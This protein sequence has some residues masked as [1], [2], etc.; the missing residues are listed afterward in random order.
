MTIDIQDLRQKVLGDGRLISFPKKAEHLL[1]FLGNTR[2]E[3]INNLRSRIVS[4]EDERIR[5]I[6][7]KRSRI[8]EYI[9]DFW[10]DSLLDIPYMAYSYRGMNLAKRPFLSPTAPQENSLYGFYE[11]YRWDTFFQNHGIMLAGGFDVAINQLLNLADVFTEYK[12]IPN[13]LASAFLSHAHPPMEAVGFR[14]C[15]QSGANKGDWCGKVVDAIKG[16]LLTEWWDRGIPKIHL[17][18]NEELAERF[19]LLTRYTRIHFDPIMAGCE[20]GKDHNW[21]TIKY[22]YEYLPVQ[23][24][25]LIFS[26]LDTLVW[27]Y[28]D[29]TLGNDAQQADLFREFRSAFVNDFQKVFWHSGDKWEGFRNY[30]I[31]KGNEGAIL[32][33]DLAAEV[34]PLFTGIATQ[35][36]ADVTKNNL[37]KY[38][39]GSY[40][41][42]A[43]SLELRNGGSIEH[44]PAA[45]HDWKWQWEHPNCWPP[46]MYAAVEG[47]KRYGYK[48]EAIEY[49][50]NWLKYI[51]EEFE[52]NGSFPE[53]TS[54]DKAESLSH[55]FYG[56]V[57]GFGWTIGV[58]LSF[59]KDLSDSGAEL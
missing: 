38:Y 27:Y 3:R 14:D 47:L 13:V 7:E 9:Y 15:L 18:Q 54:F 36:Q 35:E 1:G 29:E 4:G 25:S 51:E 53:K 48:Q 55:G 59:L 5:K 41:L 31:R 17:R 50:A 28:G 33:G 2:G 58:Y 42:A 37:E 8:F 57:G 56:K 23:L 52:L 39:K 49:E 34:F 10:A 32:Y 30:S 11:Q 24:N 40:G 21:V 6:R 44:E 46:L 43:T 16:E 12:R 26:I 19:G 22:G 20:D 45:P